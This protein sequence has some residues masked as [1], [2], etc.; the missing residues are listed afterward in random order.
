MN[1]TGAVCPTDTRTKQIGR[2]LGPIMALG[3]YVLTANMLPEP[4][5][6]AAASGTLMI[7]FWITEAI[8][9]AATA[10]L[11]LV[12]FPTLGVADIKQAAAPFANPV[13]FLFLGGF[14]I[15]AAVERCELH[16]RVALTVVRAVGVSPGKLLAGCMAATAFMSMWISNTAATVL[17]LPIG[18]SLI[19]MLRKDMSTSG[20]S[21][22]HRRIECCFLL[23]I[24]YSANIGGLGTIVGTPPNA[25]LAGFL[26]EQG[27]TIGFGRWMLF[28][29]PLVILFLGACWL[30]L[31][32]FTLDAVSRR[33]AVSL[34][35]VDEQYRELGPM[36][37]AQWTVLS[38][39][40]STV[41]LW[42]FREPLMHWDRLV[43]SCPW[44]ARLDDASI[45][46]AA[47]IALFLLPGNKA[48]GERILD[49][50]TANRL[51]WDVL[52]LIGGGMSLGSTLGATG[53]TEAMGSNLQI[54]LALPIVLLIAALTGLVI[55]LTETISNTAITAAI[56]PVLFGLGEQVSGG[57]LLLLVP[58]TLAASCAF[59][60]PIGTPPNAVVF[61]TGRVPMHTMMR[62]GLWLNL[63]GTI[64]IPGLMYLLGW[65]LLA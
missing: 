52:I 47:A 56:L 36:T 55:F 27:I 63:I 16:R 37:R 39:F 59:M 10:L 7:V 46:M 34:A 2:L 4:A 3:V 51:P 32:R 41:A 49:W 22:D 38:V 31:Y 35:A 43:E 14:M 15:A 57:P 6:F 40:L 54:F 50:E 23:G 42:I 1:T 58:A 12:L 19:S 24:A 17:M 30:L 33:A 13:I 8:P 20:T 5:R 65:M 29:V 9:L 18:A 26:Q 44:V 61:A 21:G 11:P 25:L 53:L 28:A 64:L 62:Y 48:S 45:A 60:L